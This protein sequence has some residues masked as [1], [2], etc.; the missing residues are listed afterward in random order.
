EA[1]MLEN[2]WLYAFALPIPVMCTILGFA[3]KAKGF[4]HKKNVAVGLIAT[5]ILCIAFSFNYFLSDIGYD[6]VASF[7]ETTRIALPEEIIDE[8][9]IEFTDDTQPS[10]N[11]YIYS[12][13]RV[14]FEEYSA[15]AFENSLDQDPRWLNEFPE[16]FDEILL[17]LEF[18]E[19]H[20]TANKMML[21]SYYSGEYNTVPYYEEPYNLMAVFYYNDTNMLEIFEY[22]YI[23]PDKQNDENT[24]EEIM[25]IKISEVITWIEWDSE[26]ED[27]N[28]YEVVNWFE[29][30]SYQFFS[31][32]WLLEKFGYGNYQEIVD[33]GFFIP[34]SKT[35]TVAIMK[36]FVASHNEGEEIDKEIDNIIKNDNYGY[37]SGYAVA[38]RILMEVNEDILDEYVQ[39][40]KERLTKDAVKWCEEN[41]IAYYFENSEYRKIDINAIADYGIYYSDDEDANGTVLFDVKKFETISFDEAKENLGA[42]KV[43]ELLYSGRFIELFRTDV[44]VLQKDYVSAYKNGKYLAKI[45]K[46]MAKEDCPFSEAFEI[47]FGDGNLYTEWDSFINK[48]LMSDAIEWCNK[49]NIDFFISKDQPDH[50][51][52]NF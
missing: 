27:D 6:P 20:E 47:V 9:T 15:E 29:K 22:D 18:D 46:T 26:D 45:E 8:Y 36:Q 50:L 19:G 52:S 14:I 3:L 48:K 12:M 51:G 11:G 16:E 33:S 44:T 30:S 37:D 41:G 10:D 34:V 17:P 42:G 4:S 7:T 43:S 39:F 5:V 1:I 2:P 40:E 38:F 23:G 32:E 35:D 21:Y 28:I 25:K 31:T 24:K 13:S 49:H